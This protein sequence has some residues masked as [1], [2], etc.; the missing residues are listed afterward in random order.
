MERDLSS[1]L[2]VLLKRKWYILVTLLASIGVAVFLTARTPRIYEAGATLFVGQL[3]APADAEGVHVGVVLSELSSRL[4]GSYANII[5][6]KSVAAEAVSEYSLPVSPEG[7]VGGIRAEIVPTT[8]VISLVYSSTEPAVAQR[9]VNAVA[10]VFVDRISSLEQG[11]DAAVNVSIID[12]AGLPS[13]PI[14]PNPSRNVI[15]AIVLGLA[16]GLGLAFLIDRFDVTVRHRDDIERLGLR[17]LGL[18]PTLSGPPTTVYLEHDPHGGAGE[19]FRKLR[20]SLGFLGVETPIQTMLVSSPGP[21]E[22]KTTIAL[23]MAAAFALG[24]LRTLLVEADL[25]RPSLHN[26]FPARGTRGLTT[27]IVG[28]VPLT[29]A[30][31]ET[32]VPNLSVLLAGAIPPNPVELLG[33]EQTASIIDRLRRM[34]DIVVVDAPP[35]VPVADPATLATMCDGVLLVARA[36]K[37]DR[38][39]LVESVDTINRA[40]ANLLGVVLNSL[41]P[42]ET[43]FD[44]GYYAYV[45]PSK[46]AVERPA[47]SE[48]AV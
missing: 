24:G 15:V 10:D 47:R 7:V 3:Q 21:S 45:E 39:Q 22:G 6:S 11:G 42:S 44:Y 36:D 28:Q 5:T 16:G 23:N 9:T 4:L 8:Y 46:D 27:A 32:D 13:V 38:N 12:R 33:S 2:R 37:T 35:F 17:L 29:D 26:V 14:S 19:A 30:I 20:T 34:Y 18:I 25:R 43:D 48:R 1:Y 40:G 41:N 31:T